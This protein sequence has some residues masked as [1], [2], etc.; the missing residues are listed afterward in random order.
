M[1]ENGTFDPLSREKIISGHAIGGLLKV[2]LIPC[3]TASVAHKSL[4]NGAIC[5]LYFSEFHSSS[6]P[7]GECF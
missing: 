5:V 7:F 3:T 2:A 6:T 1:N 4:R